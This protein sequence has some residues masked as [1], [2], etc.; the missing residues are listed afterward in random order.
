MVRI[1]V[2]LKRRLLSNS[3]VLPVDGFRVKMCTW[4]T[5]NLLPLL[6][7]LLRGKLCIRTKLGLAV[8]TS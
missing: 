4:V 3:P 6:P 8:Q 2:T 1:V 7:P 5:L